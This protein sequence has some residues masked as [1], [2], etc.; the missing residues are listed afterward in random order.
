MRS[1]PTNSDDVID[2][3]DVIA[4][5]EELESER[6]SLESDRDDAEEEEESASGEKSDKN[7]A[8][9]AREALEKWDESDEAAE[10]KALQAFAKEA[11]GYAED[12]NYGATLIRES[13][14]KDYAQELVSDIGDMPKNIPDYIVIDWDA[15]ADN[16]RQDYTTVEF[17]G[18]DYYVR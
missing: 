15:T 16:I 8:T 4:R 12:W 17:D 3:R 2:S 11:E 13:Y 10:L 6:A 1:T 5:I 18:V 7:D 14:F 9:A